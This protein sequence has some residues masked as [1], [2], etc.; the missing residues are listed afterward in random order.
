MTEAE[1]VRSLSP[2]LESFWKICRQITEYFACSSY[3]MVVKIKHC[4]MNVAGA[5]LGR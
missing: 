5:G 1:E 4:I 2:D 3:C